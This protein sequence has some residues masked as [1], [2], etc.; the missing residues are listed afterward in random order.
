MQAE[1]EELR[2]ARDGLEHARTLLE[3]RDEVG[4]PQGERRP[5]GERGDHGNVG[6]GIRRQAAGLQVDGA[7]DLAVQNERHDQL[8]PRALPSFNVAGI[9]RHV[10]NVEHRAGPRRR[11]NEAAAVQR[12]DRDRVALGPPVSAARELDERARRAVQEKEAAVL[13]AEVLD[14][15]VDDLVEKNVAVR[16]ARKERPRRLGES[17]LLAKKRRQSVALEADLLHELLLLERRRNMPRRGF[18]EL[19]V[20]VRPPAERPDSRRP[21]EPARVAIDDD[22]HREKGPGPE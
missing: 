2:G 16:R 21:H 14:E 13:L 18:Q 7:D 10:R 8:R 3:P 1:V 20:P 9:A 15:R 4:Q 11:G 12:D 19:D 5:L 6:L 22:R 17:P